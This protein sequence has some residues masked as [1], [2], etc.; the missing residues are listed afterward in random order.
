MHHPAVH[1]TAD[2]WVIAN[3]RDTEDG[4]IQYCKANNVQ[5]VLSGHTHES[6]ILDA[7]GESVSPG[8]IDYPQ[9]IQTPSAAKQEIWDFFGD[10]I[11]Y[12]IVDVANNKASPRAYSPTPSPIDDLGNV[13]NSPTEEIKLFS[14]AHVHVYDSG[15][16]HVGLTPSGRAERGIPRSFYF[17][18][19]VTDDGIKV[20]P[21]QI[22]IF[23]SFDHYRHEVVGTEEG[24]Y[25]LNITYTS[26]G[27]Q[28]IFEAI[29]I[30]TSPGQIH[31]YIIDWN[32]LSQGQ[33]GV[34][35][36]I[37]TDGD[38]D[39]EATVISDGVL[40]RDEIGPLPVNGYVSISSGLVS[41]DRRTAKFS[42]NVTVKNTSA[43]VVN[44]PVWLVIQSISNPAVTLA[45]ADG[46]TAD[47]KPY[48]DL[49]G[50][51]GDG[52]LAPGES[53][54]KRIYFNNPNRV[55]FTFKP[56]VRGIILP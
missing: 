14:P 18:S 48:L 46:T 40:T 34:T 52:K 3:N 50:L 56:S 9:F 53:I 8:T 19:I 10:P 43:T 30:P 26:G 1:T 39:F 42:A 51:L 44:S 23:N 12:R 27:K 29:G 13:L 22:I 2:E 33:D 16:Q 45:G 41:F 6:H 54:S 17:S 5:L 47:G 55:Q 7:D 28:T 36:G 31:D 37:D 25:R 24:T 21:E 32:A 38:G 35:V 4:F 15:G 11:G 20:L 49:S